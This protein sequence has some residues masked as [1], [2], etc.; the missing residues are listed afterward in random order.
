M[1][2]RTKGAR[3]W[4]EYL[5]EKSQ[6]A[7]PEYGFPKGR[8]MDQVVERL[9]SRKLFSPP[10]AMKD[11]EKCLQFETFLNGLQCKVYLVHI[12]A[13]QLP[14]PDRVLRGQPQMYWVT[15]V[16]LSGHAHLGPPC[17]CGLP[18]AKAAVSLYEAMPLK[19]RFATKTPPLVLY[20]GTAREATQ[21]I[22]TSGLL[23]TAKPGMLGPGVYLARW[24]KASTFA[25]KAGGVLVRCLVFPGNTYVMTPDDVCTCGCAQ[26]YVD[27]N[28]HYGK[29][30]TTT[31]VGDNSLP[32]T[33]RAEWCV[34]DP[35]SV[36]VDGCF[37]LGARDGIRDGTRGGDR[38]HAP[39]HTPAPTYD[40]DR[41]RDQDQGHDR[42]R[43]R[44]QARDKTDDRRLR[45]ADD[46]GCTL[47]PDDI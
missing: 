9:A 16:E 4:F 19:L 43:D 13:T 10:S 1:R 27:H 37:E 29:G 11:M 23:P 41:D 18:V 35:T 24:D 31:Y 5:V 38:H 40:R 26:A 45:R 34:R 39:T 42:D 46:P 30:Y 22:A 7:G 17:V 28:T 25:D 15:G 32:A 44:D 14:R 36:L 2:T 21:S 8:T 20:H 3:K 47:G 33:K 12:E 6:G